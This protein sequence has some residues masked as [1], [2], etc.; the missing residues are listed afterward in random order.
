MAYIKTGKLKNSD[1]VS[2]V[3]TDIFIFV[4]SIYYN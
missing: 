3:V 1:L 4:V 2:E